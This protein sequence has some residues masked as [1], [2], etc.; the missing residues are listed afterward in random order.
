MKQLFDKHFNMGVINVPYCL[1]N[2]LHLWI[3]HK[4]IR[5]LC[6]GFCLYSSNTVFSPTLCQPPNF[7]FP[8]LLLVLTL[9]IPFEQ[10]LQPPTSLFSCCFLSL[11]QKEKL[12]PSCISLSQC[13]SCSCI[14]ASLLFYS[15]ARS[16]RGLIQR[17]PINIRGHETFMLSVYL[18]WGY[19][20]CVCL[21]FKGCF[22]LM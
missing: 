6:F 22:L 7:F 16:S 1:A 17:I 14:V 3:W 13:P 11:L 18:C 12:S 19:F 2:Q 20:M 5:G 10:F 4:A 8:G 15:L 21:Y 9:W